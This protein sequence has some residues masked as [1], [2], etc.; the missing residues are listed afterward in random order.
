M[1]PRNRMSRGA[2]FNRVYHFRRNTQTQFVYIQPEGGSAPNWAQGY[3]F[4]LNQLVAYNEFTQ[5]FDMYRINMVIFR[6]IPTATQLNVQTD[7]N[8]AEAPLVYGAVDFN[9]AEAPASV[10]EMSQY[11]NVR[12]FPMTRP[13]TWK[14]RPRTATPVYRDSVSN[15]YIQNS[16]RLWIDGQYPDVPHYGLKLWVN[17][18]TTNNVYRSR[19]E[20]TFYISFKNLK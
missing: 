15:A 10:D 7:Q 19:I 2:I 11:G 16:P 14:I 3:Q 5:L 6:L 18:G 9:S 13:M 4:Q 12:V 17:G 20:M 1:V 8:N